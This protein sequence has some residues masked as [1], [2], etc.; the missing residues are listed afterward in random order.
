[1]SKLHG[2]L[3]VALLAV[4]TAPAAAGEKTKPNGA[5]A[6]ETPQAVFAAAREAAKTEDWK[7]FSNCLTAESRDMLG[8]VVV[9]MGAAMKG[10]LNALYEKEDKDKKELIMQVIK[11]LLKPVMDAYARHG[12]TEAALDKM[13]ASADKLFGGKAEPAQVKKVLL[14][15]VEPVKDRTAFVTD[16]MTALKKLMQTFGKGD[17]V[18]L[19]NLFFAKDGRLEDLKVEGDSAKAVMIGT[20]KGEEKRDPIFFKKQG[21]GWK[22]ELPM[23]LPAGIGEKKGKGAEPK[24]PGGRSQALPGGPRQRRITAPAADRVLR[25]VMAVRQQPL[26]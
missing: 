20:K 5:K 15:A 16:V 8:G 19:G 6:F 10:A 9:F 21:G 25:E 13:V 12:V 3:A 11:G 24:E 26:R 1:M 18:S 2:I 14:K 23:D 4:A 7:G 22:I 17:E